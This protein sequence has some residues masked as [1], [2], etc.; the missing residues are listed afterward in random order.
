[1][2][3]GLFFSVCTKYWYKEK[4]QILFLKCQII[5]HVH[6]WKDILDSMKANV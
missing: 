3:K 6:G 4:P 2:C 1:M 5:D